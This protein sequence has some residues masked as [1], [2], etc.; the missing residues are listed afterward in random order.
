M[1]KNDDYTSK[2]NEIYNKA[3]FIISKNEIEY[4]KQELN[5]QN[6]HRAEWIDYVVKRADSQKAI[7][8]VLI[9]SFLK[10]IVEPN[11]DVRYHKKDLPNGYSGRTLDTKYV[12]PFIKEK[13]QRIAMNESGWLTRSIEQ[14]HPFTKDFPG[15]IKDKKLKDYFLNILD[16]L[17]INNAD[18]SIYLLYLFVLIIQKMNLEKELFSNLLSD[19]NTNKNELTISKIIS[20]LKSHF[21]YKY[22]EPGT[23]YLPVIA[24]YSIYKL[25]IRDVKRYE[26]KKLLPLK[27][28]LVSD[29][30]SKSIA[31]I[32]I[33]AQNGQYF[34][35]VEVKHNKPIN[36]EMVSDVYEKI[37]NTSIERYYILTTAIPNIK[38]GEEDQVNELLINIKKETGFEIIVNGLINSLNY[39]LR[40]LVN[41]N[42]FLEVY[43]TTL[44][45][46]YL[47]NST[48]KNNHVKLW[49]EIYKGP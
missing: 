36:K 37:K 38:T 35:G 18:P 32:E 45:E 39:Y 4:I 15:K 25:L 24:I 43:G 7:V 34:E 49:N 40:L 13:F 47:K 19:V 21:F 9:T 10:K 27:G 41:P 11:Q 1:T 48:I 33:V 8:T 23:S 5:E 16:D 31:D 14:D 17:E 29:L 22:D 30:K 42:E 6:P 12:T 46:E 26:N 44:L 3:E 20:L 28:H 2:L